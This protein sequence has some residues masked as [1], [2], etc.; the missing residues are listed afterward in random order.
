[1][2]ALPIGP[3]LLIPAIAFGLQDAERVFTT[4]NTYT[5]FIETRIEV[6][7]IEKAF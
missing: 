7:F 3:L 4:A 1:L 5:A 2:K 6:P